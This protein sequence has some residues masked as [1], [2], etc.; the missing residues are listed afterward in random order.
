[1]EN[2]L[3][4]VQS[5]SSSFIRDPIL[6][7]SELLNFYMLLSTL[8]CFS[9]CAIYPKSLQKS[10][11]IFPLFFK[12]YLT[13]ILVFGFILSI[14]VFIF[15]FFDTPE[16]QIIY[17]LVFN[18][19]LMAFC[20]FIQFL[21]A[22]LAVSNGFKPKNDESFCHF[23]TFLVLGALVLLLLL[24]WSGN[25]LQ[26]C[27]TI[28]Y[29]SFN[30]LLF[31]TSVVHIVMVNRSRRAEKSENPKNSFVIWQLVMIINQKLIISTIKKLDFIVTPAI[32][33][34]TNMFLEEESKSLASSFQVPEKRVEKNRGGV[35]VE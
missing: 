33:T 4:F 27:S 31:L 16:A 32:V 8:F 5:N 7:N 21:W 24:E 3:N 20:E 22:V 2:L 15:V 13:I 18:P 11:K 23:G 26:M 19:V 34:I 14:F 30:V 35:R 28:F 29:I 6:D 12:T 1:M 9:Y 25:W 17:I 10:V